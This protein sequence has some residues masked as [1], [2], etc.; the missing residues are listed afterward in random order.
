M[1]QDGFAALVLLNGRFDANP[2]ELVTGIDGCNQSTD[3]KEPFSDP[4]RD[5]RLGIQ[6]EHVEQQAQ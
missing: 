3:S 6:G 1:T 5:L 2:S 4:K